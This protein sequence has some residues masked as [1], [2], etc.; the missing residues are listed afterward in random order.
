MKKLDEIKSIKENKKM[1]K[2]QKKDG[3]K[4]KVDFEDEQFEI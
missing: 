1:N 2:F 4:K 3:A